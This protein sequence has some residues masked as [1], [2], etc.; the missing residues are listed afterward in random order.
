METYS[1]EISL[2]WEKSLINVALSSRQQINISRG[3]WGSQ[4][5]PPKERRWWPG[6][7]PPLFPLLPRLCQHSS[8]SSHCP[9]LAPLGAPTRHK[10]DKIHIKVTQAARQHW[11]EAFAPPVPRWGTGT[12]E[13]APCTDRH[14]F[15]G[16]VLVWFFPPQSR[17]VLCQVL[18][19]V[20]NLTQT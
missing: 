16:C 11:Q 14:R 8:S 7:G 9:G 12:T 17:H 1:L 15:H 20:S 13:Q 5:M 18:S 4:E 10:Q 6:Q 19:K 3:F 2:K